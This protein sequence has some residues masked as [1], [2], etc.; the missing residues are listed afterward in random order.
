MGYVGIVGDP[1]R[2]NPS[3]HN[4]S[5]KFRLKGAQHSGISV[6]EALERVRLSQGTSYL[7]HDVSMDHSGKISL[8]IRWSG[9][10]S[11]IYSIP[12]STD[13]HGYVDVQSLA[14][15]TARAIVHFMDS[16]GISLS[17]NRVVMHRLEENSPGIWIPVLMTH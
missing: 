6:N 15:R 5:I 16:N 12:L 11:N 17:W 14:R 8:K 1:Y 10:R 2:R 4:T 7:M 9:Y 13:Y 3:G